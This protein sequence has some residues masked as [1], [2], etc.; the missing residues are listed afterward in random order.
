MIGRPAEFS[1]H[2]FPD[3]RHGVTRIPFVLL[4]FIIWLASAPLNLGCP[5][6]EATRVSDAPETHTPQKS[7]R[8]AVISFA[9]TVEPDDWT[10][11][12][13]GFGLQSVLT[14]S[15]ND[16]GLFRIVEEKPE[17]RKRLGLSTPKTWNRQGNYSPDE[18][19][20][21]ASG[22]DADLLAY[23][24]VISYGLHQD[25]FQG[26]P[27]TKI[28]EV[29]RVEIEVC[30]YEEEGR[31]LICRTGEGSAV[32]SAKSVLVVYEDDGRLSAKCLIGEASK[33]AV[34]AALD[35]LLSDS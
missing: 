7:P 23:A 22:L 12:R 8:L 27:F 32:K 34:D 25:R 5:K 11:L 16:T 14:R 1:K 18:L 33:K 10:D 13:L 29:A 30:L 2:S 9:W 6:T 28:K 19:K 24:S 17:I 31:G 4:L 26:G 21:I 3:T 15:L 20:A 35:Q